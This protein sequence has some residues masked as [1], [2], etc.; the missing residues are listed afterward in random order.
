MDDQTVPRPSTYVRMTLSSW[1]GN[2]PLVILA[3]IVFSLLCAPAFFLLMSGL[4]VP[5]LIAVALTAVPA[6]VALLAQLSEIVRDLPTHIGAMLRAFPRY[7]TRGAVLGLLACFPLLA[8]MF[9]LPG[10]ADHQVPLATWIGLAADVLGLLVIASLLM[11]AV[12]ILVIHD[13]AVWVALRNAA[14]LVG[15][16]IMNTL[17]L[18]GMAALFVLATLRV[19][20]GLVFFWPAFWGLFIV[21]NCRMVVSEELTRQQT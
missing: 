3:G 15:R 6:W 21:N 12:P 20:S 9:T 7:W 4:F 18:L 8:A 10:F 14:V 11:Y 2:L 16:H 1:W 19:S 17:G 5:A 13:V